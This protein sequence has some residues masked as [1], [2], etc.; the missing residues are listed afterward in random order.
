MVLAL[1][2][3]F[4]MAV[5][6]GI[7]P[8]IEGY[9]AEMDQTKVYDRH[10]MRALWEFLAG[11]L[12]G[13]EEWAGKDRAIF[14]K[15][16]T[17]RLPELF[18]NIRHDTTK[19]WDISIEYVLNDRDPRRHR[20]LFDFC[21][22]TALNADFNSGS[23]FDLARRVQLVRSVIRCLQ[24]RFNAWADE[25]VELYF[26]SVACPYAEVRSL[27]ASVINAIDQLKFYP[28]Y[29]S[30]TALTDEVLQDTTSEKDIMQIRSGLFMPQLQ[31]IMDSLPEWKAER[32]HGPKAVLSVHDT[33]ALTSMCLSQNME[34]AL[35]VVAL[36]W[37][38]VELSD[39]H[40]VATFPYI[41]PIL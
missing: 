27:M 11:L 13:S 3:I 19:C 39:V 30:A 1:A 2:Q 24:W 15:W 34:N 7:R 6:D 35:I 17:P 16:V 37:L 23:A 33:S 9:L 5:F 38:S 32:P 12:R 20:P 40:A 29:P 28:S 10:K 31:K 41:I 22:N 14:W 26:K 18:A 36:S 8:I 25:F 4:G 21:I